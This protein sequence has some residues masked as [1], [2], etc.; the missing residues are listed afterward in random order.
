MGNTI[1][2]E[3]KRIEQLCF[4]KNAA[5]RVMVRGAKGGAGPE[6]WA[7]QEGMEVPQWKK[8]VSG[9]EKR[10]LTLCQKAKDDLKKSRN[11]L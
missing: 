8:T 10:K 4:F 11:V 6:L 2:L 7:Y 9:G 3:T 5:Q 1:G